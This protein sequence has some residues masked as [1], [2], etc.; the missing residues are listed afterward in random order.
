MSRRSSRL[1]AVATLVVLALP[2]PALAQGGQRHWQGIDE[3]HLQDMELFHYLGDH[4]RE[5]TRTIKIL[6]NGVETQTESEE[7]EVAAKI[8][9][10]VLSMSARV[11]ERRP[12]HMRDPL[13]REVFAHADRIVMQH[14]NTPNGIKVIETSDDPYVAK[15]IQAHAEVVSLFITHGREEMRKDHP[16]PDR[17]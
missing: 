12:I 3:Q 10:H 14:E 8:R 16:V 7:P 17:N 6:P 15:L 5:I 13:F 4:G 1:A 11:K 2:L 9:E